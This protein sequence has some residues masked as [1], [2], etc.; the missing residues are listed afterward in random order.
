LVQREK[1]TIMTTI[2]EVFAQVGIK[3]K[4]ETLAEL[5]TLL[6]VKK[7]QKG[8]KKYVFNGDTFEAKTPLQMKQ[9]VLAIKDAGEVDLKTWAEKLQRYEGFK[10]QQPVERI[11][12]FYKKRM[13]NEGLVRE[14]HAQRRPR[15]R[16]ACSTKASSEMLS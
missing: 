11:V 15:P 10:T 4:E 3:V 7:P 9:A 2:A 13:L 14:A 16:S 12:A 5:E 8:S 1:E 6:Q